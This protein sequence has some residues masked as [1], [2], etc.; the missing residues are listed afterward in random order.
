[1]DDRLHILLTTPYTQLARQS[2]I[3]RAELNSLIHESR[4]ALQNPFSDITD[5]AGRLYQHLLAPI[6]AD[7]EAAKA[8]TLLVS[9]DGAL[10]YVPL[11]ALYDGE[12]YV[13]E[14]YR[15]VVFTAATRDKLG[16]QDRTEPKVA[17]LGLTHAYPGFDALPAV[18]YEL[19]GIVRQTDEDDGVMPGEILLDDAFTQLAFQA[20]LDQQYPLLHVASHFSFNPG[21]E[22]DS[23]LLLGDGSR[24]SLADLRSRRYRFRNVELLT[25][26]ACNTAVGQQAEGSEVEGFGVLAQRQGA[27]GVMATLWP[28]ADTSTGL[29]MQ[30]FYRMLAEEPALNKAEA[31]RQVQLA[32]IGGEISAANSTGEARGETVTGWSRPTGDDSTSTVPDD[33]RH[34]YYWAPFILMGNWL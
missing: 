18:A 10:R 3:G 8:E 24:L 20:V 7:L 1:M 32:F 17:G 14:R 31:M 21:T 2:A 25:L 12:R 4:D 11:A 23:F 30:A 15:T 34:P 5:P 33:W 28:V 6:A 22:A 29:F 13:A 19:D 27:A 9:L 26:S 16:P